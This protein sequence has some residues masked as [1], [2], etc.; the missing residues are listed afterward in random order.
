ML[1][2]SYKQFIYIVTR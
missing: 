2:G 1:D